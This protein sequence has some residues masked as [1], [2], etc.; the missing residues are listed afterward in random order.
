MNLQFYQF[1]AILSKR[2]INTNNFFI[3]VAEKV[4]KLTCLQPLWGQ[5]PS[6][7]AAEVGL[8]LTVPGGR[9]SSLMIA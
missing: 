5:Q 7:A 3:K 8:H 6:I 9:D 4:L 2:K 1:S